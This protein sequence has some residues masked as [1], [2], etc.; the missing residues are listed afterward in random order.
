MSKCKILWAITS[1]D[2][3]NEITEFM[4]CKEIYSVNM[5]IDKHDYFY[6]CIIYRDWGDE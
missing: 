6:A 3:E 2:L 1:D 5:A 4:K